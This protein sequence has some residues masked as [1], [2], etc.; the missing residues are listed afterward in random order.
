MLTAGRQW[1]KLGVS[2]SAFLIFEFGEHLLF[3]RSRNICFLCDWKT[4]VYEFMFI[5]YIFTWG[6][7]RRLSSMFWEQLYF[8]SKSNIFP[9]DV[10]I[11]NTL[12]YIGLQCQNSTKSAKTLYIK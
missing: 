10:T 2:P 3:L 8:K 4:F 6:G 11:C 9:Y 12:Y 7:V 5:R 1:I